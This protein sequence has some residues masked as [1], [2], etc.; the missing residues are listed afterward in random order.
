MIRGGGSFGEKTCGHC[1][2]AGDCLP[3]ETGTSGIE[4]GSPN[5]INN[6]IKKRHFLF[7][8][9]NDKGFQAVPFRITS[10]NWQDVS[11]T[12][13]EVFVS[14]DVSLSSHFTPAGH[15]HAAAGHDIA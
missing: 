3:H 8:V 4:R 9:E 10:D 12:E 14:T 5:L 2:W 13:K 15:L 11:L 6:E 1:R 7:L